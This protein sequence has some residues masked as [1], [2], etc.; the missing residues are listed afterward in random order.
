MLVEIVCCFSV[1]IRLRELFKHLVSVI[2]LL[3]LLSVLVTVSLC[4]RVVFTD[5]LDCFK[6]YSLK[7]NNMSAAAALI[8]S[9][10]SSCGVSR[11]RS[12]LGLTMVRPSL[13]SAPEQPA[14][15][16]PP[17]NKHMPDMQQFLEV[18]DFW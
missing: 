9:H 4:R 3:L 11:H 7:Q 13:Q 1:I 14:L 12:T 6:V 17:V 5:S 8:R 2:F 15:E 16:P 18:F 10:P